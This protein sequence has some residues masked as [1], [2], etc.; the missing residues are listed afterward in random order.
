MVNVSY[1]YAV[2]CCKSLF[3]A[4]HATVSPTNPEPWA[5]HNLTVVGDGYLPECGTRIHLV[6]EELQE[7]PMMLDNAIIFTYCYDGLV[8]E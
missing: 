2:A 4:G 1:E 6:K 3:L 7:S 8:W 5:T